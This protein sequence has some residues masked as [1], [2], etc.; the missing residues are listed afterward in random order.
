MSKTAAQLFE[1]RE[2]RVNDAVALRAPDRVPIL[3]LT[4]FFPAYYAGI[5]CEEAM[6]DGEKAMAAWSR[7]LLDFEPDM[8]D[9]PFATRVVGAVLEALGCTHLKWAG[10]GLD[11]NASYQFIEGQYMKPEEY[12]QFLFDPTDFIL[13]TYWPRIFS[14]LKPFEKLPALHD[15]ISYYMGIAKFA[16]FDT[17]D[18]RSAVAALLH[19]AEEAARIN[20]A[21]RKWAQHSKDLGFPSQAGS[22]SQAPFDT[23]SDFLR[24]TQGAMTDMYRNP[25]K[26]LQALD[27]MLPIMLKLG[28]TAKHRG[29]PRVFIPLHKGLDGFMSGAQFRKFF[30]PTLKK[31]IEG[32]IAED[33]V[34][35]VFWEGDVTSRL[36]I[37]GDIPK[38]KAVY[39][40]E[41]TDM[42]AAKRILGDTVCLKG[43][44]PLSLMIAGTQQEVKDHCKKLIDVVGKDGG[45]IMDCSTVIDD[46]KPE[47]LRAMFEITREYGVY[48]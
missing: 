28:A 39:G 20:A 47:N 40:F 22:F 6:Y 46:A 35:F 29:A 18:M 36:E 12:D 5:T 43:A 8:S 48:R 31:L 24:G 13:R 26:L 33:C 19:A 37:I 10:H 11:A 16:A 45:F 2:K 4:G 30:W 34:P 9:N 38:G 14:A 42:F 23:I 17:P 21:A 7:F 15:I 25:D 41:R 27:K 3:L 1:E 32:L 44:V